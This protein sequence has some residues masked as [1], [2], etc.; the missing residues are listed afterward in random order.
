MDDLDLIRKLRGEAPLPDDAA[1]ERMR[2]TLKERIGLGAAEKAPPERRRAPRR[3]V[4]TTILLAA[5]LAVGGVAGAAQLAHLW[6]HSHPVTISIP[7]HNAE[8]EDIALGIPHQYVRITSEQQLESTVAE[9]APSVHLPPGHNFSAYVAWIEQ[10]GTWRSLRRVNI[11]SGMVMVADCHWQQRWLDA[12]ASHD[13]PTA[14]NSIA[15]IKSMR[16]GARRRTS[17]G[18]RICPR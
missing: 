14:R 5:G 15:V 17:T 12:E 4:V 6:S 3:R 10:L 2:G 16:L 1:R 11:A 18:G 8:G 13:G 9:F 7:P